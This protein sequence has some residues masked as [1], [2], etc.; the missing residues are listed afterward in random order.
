MQSWYHQFFQ[1]VSPYKIFNVLL[2]LTEFDKV[3][4]RLQQGPSQPSRPVIETTDT[5]GDE[6][7][8]SPSKKKV[9]SKKTCKMKKAWSSDELARLCVTGPTDLVAKPSLSTVSSVGVICLC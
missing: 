7:N 3:L 6:S 5:T 9:R 8:N 2:V 1:R 4:D